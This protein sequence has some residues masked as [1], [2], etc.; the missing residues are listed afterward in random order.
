LTSFIQVAHTNN[1]RGPIAEKASGEIFAVDTHGSEAVRHNYQKTHK[2]LKAEEIL[3]QRSVIP[4]VENRKRPGSR[5]TDGIIGPSSKKQKKNWVSS[6]ELQRLKD[7]L[8][9]TTYLSSKQIEN[10]QDATF[11]LWSEEKVTK[12]D[13]AYD[14]LEQPKAKVAPSTVSHPPI[15]M[16][17][18]GKAV[19]AIRT[20]TAG[21]S[22][23]PSF[24][25]W[26]DLLTQEGEKALEAEKKRLQIE[27][28]EAERAA[29]I[30][31]VVSEDSSGAR[32]DDESAWEGFESEFESAQ[33]LKK[34]RPE[35]K[36][37][38][39]RNKIKRR[40]DAEGQALHQSKMADKRKQARE[41]EQLARNDSVGQTS[42]S[43]VAAMVEEENI[44]SED[45]DDSVLR[46]KRLR[47]MTIPE[48]NL[49][50]VL[51]DELQESLRRLKP[52]GN[53][54][55]DRFRSLLVNGKIE[56]RKEIL[57]PKK[58]RVTYTEKWTYKDFQIL[59]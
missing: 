20:P 27:Q 59:V 33:L 28:T 48:K 32:N 54:L 12:D 2:P 5:I 31:A 56:V 30:A 45:G 49:E 50:V 39:Q 55:N 37:Q 11:D 8:D 40:K 41:L 46:R 6:K 34:K 14:Y 4:A 13:V 43:E 10:N 38:A 47:N 19:K 23:N 57:Q 16:T 24:A 53:L 22:Y 26:D 52:E 7:S 44:S 51:P 17:A 9:T 35:R 29:R 3:A 25:D 36:T 1:A 18:S 42:A 58:K 15:A 21:S